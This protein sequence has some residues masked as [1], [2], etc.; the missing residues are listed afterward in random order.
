MQLSTQQHT[1]PEGEKH[2]MPTIEFDNPKAAKTA[3]YEYLEHYGQAQL[4]N[5]LQS[6]EG[7]PV[8]VVFNAPWPV[9]PDDLLEKYDIGINF[10]VP[11]ENF[12]EAVTR[13]MEEVLDDQEFSWVLL[14]TGYKEGE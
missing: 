8:T 12:D 14:D 3:I 10:T 1:K 5:V 6:E 7:G 11:A 4:V 9:D 13:L 2:T